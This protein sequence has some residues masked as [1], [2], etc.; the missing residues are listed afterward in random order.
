M[1]GNI[2]MANKSVFTRSGREFLV[3]GK[4]TVRKKALYKLYEQRIEQVRLNDGSIL[5]IPESAIYRAL[6]DLKI[7]FD[8][9]ATLGGGRTLGGALCD[10]LLPMHNIIIEYQGPFHFTSEGQSRDF[11][12]KLSREQYGYTVA[13]IYEKDLK[14]L[15]RRLIEIVGSPNL[16]SA[17]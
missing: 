3:S 7:T 17:M 6:E 9:Q 11:W 16:A 13:Y 12:R 8:A 2:L 1:D 14:R 4:A 10:F 15:H 5:N